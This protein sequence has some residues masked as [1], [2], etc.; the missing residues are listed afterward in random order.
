MELK[1]VRQVERE[2]I[3]QLNRYVTD[4]FGQFGVLV[5]RHEL[6]S[7]MMR[8]TIDLWSGQRKCIVALTD[9]DL[10]QM[11]EVYESRQRAPLDILAK[12]YVEFR[13]ECPS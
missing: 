6:P 9:A 1:N 5:T 3:N 12:K 10:A 11:V 2:H 8:N 13:R 4:A 7:A